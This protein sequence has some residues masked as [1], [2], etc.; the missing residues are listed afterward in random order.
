MSILIQNEP[1]LYDLKFTKDELI[2]Y[3][4]DGR[5]LYIPLIWYSSLANATKEELE[6]YEILG[7][8]EGIHWKDLDEDLSVKGFLQGISTNKQVA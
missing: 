7:D 3:L 6:N 5:I 4:K 8:G 1:L 2:V